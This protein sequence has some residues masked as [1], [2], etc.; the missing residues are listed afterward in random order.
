MA[1]SADRPFRTFVSGSVSDL[2]YTLRN[3]LV[4]LSP[5]QRSHLT[6]SLVLNTPPALPGVAATLAFSAIKSE[7]HSLATPASLPPYLAPFPA[8]PGEAAYKATARNP[9][10][11]AA[12]HGGAT[13]Q[14]VAAAEAAMQAWV[15]RRE[16]DAAIAWCENEV[17]VELRWGVGWCGASGCECL[18]WGLWKG[19]EDDDK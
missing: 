3:H 13:P 15:T 4:T 5:S 7:I 6:S 16:Q 19:G 18:D 9:T 1:S 11:Q 17:G 10:K 14:I 8:K 12:P 2:K